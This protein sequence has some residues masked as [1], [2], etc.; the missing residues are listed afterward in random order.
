M[1]KEDYTSYSSEA[2][3]LL[4]GKI[5]LTD[6][7]RF[8]FEIVGVG[9]TFYSEGYHAE[10]LTLDPDYR[11]ENGGRPYKVKVYSDPLAGWA[12]KERILDGE[13]DKWGYTGATREEV[14]RILDEYNTTEI[15]THTP[16]VI[17]EAG[18]P[19]AVMYRVRISF[20]LGVHEHTA[21]V[22]TL[23]AAVIR[24]EVRWSYSYC[25]DRLC[26]MEEAKEMLL[27]IAK[28]TWDASMDYIGETDNYFG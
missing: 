1:T 25:P 4:G 22:D 2:A 14:E 11:K 23:K 12:E 18:I 5:G 24:G 16:T 19:E 8:A 21:H 15:G 27:D 6:E 17:L 3:S 26:S 20:F 10:V 7:E 9:K 28:E 13:E